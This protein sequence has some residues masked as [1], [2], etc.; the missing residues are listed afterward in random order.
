MTPPRGAA[1]ILAERVRLDFVVDTLA[2]RALGH[3]DASTCGGGFHAAAG[4]GTNA[5]SAR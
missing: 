5:R 3:C 4:T 1:Q 2:E